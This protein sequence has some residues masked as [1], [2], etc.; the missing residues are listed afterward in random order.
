MM[1]KKK[2][3]KKLIHLLRTTKFKKNTF[4][5]SLASRKNSRILCECSNGLHTDRKTVSNCIIKVYSHTK[6]IFIR[7]YFTKSR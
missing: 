4:K 7:N 6:V 5:P 1:I 3:N 2:A